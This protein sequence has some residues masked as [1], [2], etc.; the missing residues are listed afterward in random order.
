MK[1]GNARTKHTLA[2]AGFVDAA[3]DRLVLQLKVKEGGFM[4][5]LRHKDGESWRTG[6]LT[7][8]LT[9]EHQAR[10]EFEVRVED[11]MRSGW[12]RSTRG[13]ALTEIPAAK[14]TSTHRLA[15]PPTRAVRPSPAR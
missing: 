7:D 5:G 2:T 8:T 14:T 3:G 12:R 6:F 10:K 13:V 4:I 15:P 1:K 9:T 11:A